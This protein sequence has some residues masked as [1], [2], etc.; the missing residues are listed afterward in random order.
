MTGIRKDAFANT[1]RI[2]VEVDKPEAER[3]SYLHPDAFGQPRER[4]TEWVHRLQSGAA[5]RQA[6]GSRHNR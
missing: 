6:P 2:P 4:G 1:H 5:S 3:G